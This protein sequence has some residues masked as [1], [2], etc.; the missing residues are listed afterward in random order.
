MTKGKKRWMAM[1]L[2]VGLMMLTAPPA[3]A[4]TISLKGAGVALW[5]FIV[6]SAVIILL[7]LIP[8]AILIFS[9][10]GALLSSSRK[11]ENPGEEA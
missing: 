10:F 4:R 9:F 11:R 6:I 2:L 7:Q 1:M 3:F 5:I 8:A